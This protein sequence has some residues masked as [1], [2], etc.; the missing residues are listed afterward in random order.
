MTA[1]RQKAIARAVELMKKG[2]PWGSAL[3]RFTR[4]EM[5]ER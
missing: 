3:R 4:D 5:H 1:A 2:L